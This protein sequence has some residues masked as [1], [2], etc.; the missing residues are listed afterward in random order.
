MTTKKKPNE[1]NEFMKEKLRLEYLFENCI[2]L[3]NRIIRITGP[4]GDAS[5]EDFDL[6]LTEMEKANPR[7]TITVRINS[8]GGTVYDALAIVGRIKATKCRVITEGYGHIMSAATLILAAGDIRR[9]SSFSWFMYHKSSYMIGGS[10]DD[11]KEAV[12]QAER[13]EK[14]WAKKMTTMSTKSERFW[15]DCCNKRDYYV[16]A[17][18]ALKLGVIDEII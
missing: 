2:D 6:Q 1:D 17:E 4:I 9:M 18:E 8:P 12:E 11:I 5:F 10:H 7:K 14:F 13:E 3:K 15:L 16:T